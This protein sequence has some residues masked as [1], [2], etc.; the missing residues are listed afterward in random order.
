MIADISKAMDIY[1][2][3]ERVEFRALLYLRGGHFDLARADLADN[4]GKACD[5]YYMISLHRRR[6]R[7]EEDVL[8]SPEH[9][10]F[11]TVLRNYDMAIEKF[12]AYLDSRGPTKIVSPDGP[13]VLKAVPNADHLITMIVES[14]DGR[15]VWREVTAASAEDG[16]LAAWGNE[17]EIWLS[18]RRLFRWK[19][20]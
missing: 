17:R 15:E 16:W 6:T 9:A 14:I 8:Q 4:E 5:E 3:F 7:A 20:N 11:K 1:E 13:F 19:A 18:S 2:R 10:H 12:Q